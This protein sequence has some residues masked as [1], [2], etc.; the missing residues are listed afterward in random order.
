MP[1]VVGSPQWKAKIGKQAVNQAAPYVSPGQLPPA[2]AAQMS[3]VL[4]D[5]YGDN[6]DPIQAPAY[7]PP[8]TRTS[9]SGRD[10]G[11]SG[12]GGLGAP[13]PVFAAP[14]TFTAEPAM[15]Q[16]PAVV[17]DAPASQV[18]VPGESFTTVGNPNTTFGGYERRRTSR[19]PKTSLSVTPEMIRRAA[20]QR[21]G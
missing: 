17:A 15:V 14:A 20:T 2:Q 12:G 13:A 3:A 21:M 11:E 1:N 7:V 4:P 9:G 5:V 10:T 19:G 6:A 8:P 18:N 16:P